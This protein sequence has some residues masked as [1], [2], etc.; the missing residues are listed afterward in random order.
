MVKILLMLFGVGFLLAMIDIL[1]KA[2]KNQ[3]E[4]KMLPSAYSGRCAA[5]RSFCVA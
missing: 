3:A 5:G 1:A 2:A 4:G